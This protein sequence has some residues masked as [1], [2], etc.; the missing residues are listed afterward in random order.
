MADLKI[1][2]LP[3]L[4]GSLL[5]ETDPVAVA[6]LSASETKSLTALQLATGIA[7]M[8]PAS[9]IPSSSVALTIPAGSIG[10]TE[11]ADDSVTADKLA[12]NSSA[13]AGST[14]GTGTFVGQVFID[15]ATN[16]AFYWNGSA[17]TGFQGDTALG[18]I[19]G[20]TGPVV[21][22]PVE[23]DGD[24]VLNTA[25]EA[26][27]GAAEFV[28]GP[29]SGAGAVDYR[30]II[31]TDLPTAGTTKGAVVVS[32]NGLRMDGNTLEIDNDVTETSTFSVCKVDV[33][34]LVTAHQPIG[35]T[36]LPI[37]TTT[38]VGG[39]MVGT[40][41]SIAGG[42]SLS[43]DTQSGVG[44]FTKVTINSQ[45]VVTSGTVL[46]DTD[47]P[48]LPAE[49]LTTGFLDPAR[50][51]D[52]SIER[53]KLDD[54]SIAFIQE[55]PPST[56]DATLYAGCLWYQPSTAQLRMW[57]ATF[58]A[59]VGFGRLSADNL[60]FGGTINADTAKVTGV[61]SAG[62]TA[63]LIIGGALPAATDGLGGLYVVVDTAGSNINATPSVVYAS[64]D[65]CLCIS[66]A[67]GWVRIQTAAGGGSGANLLNELLDVTLGAPQM[68]DI[69]VY[70][71]NALW[72]N[73][74]T[75]DGGTY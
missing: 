1:S 46:D 23:T 39:V 51:T 49:Q 22:S 68:G 73:V 53:K 9:S 60:R 62:I 33:K 28:A 61:T 7:S 71:S 44:T 36:D 75:L 55:A 54:Y 70:S 72:Q 30:Q 37:A 11:L 34:G 26:S 58:W 8:F 24:V 43:L 27:T 35:P 45:G 4:S 25:F 66:D 64:G 31:G 2:Q 69:L 18:N 48:D 56:Q 13:I 74:N 14:G 63:G 17:W 67:E 29:T 16:H 40:G 50:I 42:G 21:I 12:D 3:P 10:T 15:T 57:S 6:D 65:W 5:Q 52:H 38:T 19:A 59:D 20:G 41:L 32:G 47:I